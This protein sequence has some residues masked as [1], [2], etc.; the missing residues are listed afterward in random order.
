M[1]SSVGSCLQWLSCIA[2]NRMPCCALSRNNVDGGGRRKNGS[3]GS[4]I[5]NCT[6]VQPTGASRRVDVDVDDDDGDD[7]DDDDD[8]DGDDD[9]DDDDDNGDDD[10]DDNDN[11]DYDDDD[12]NDAD[13]DAATT[14]A[15][16]G[17]GKT[18]ICSHVHRFR[19][20]RKHERF[21]PLGD[22]R[23]GKEGNE[24]SREEQEEM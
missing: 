6:A 4:Q 19:I 2:S 14:I 9:D 21:S 13:Y 3:V 22:K 7:D 8:D 16:I 24:T 23:W 11:D 12:D 18:S 17:D 10:D 1:H 5:D 20:V 15:V